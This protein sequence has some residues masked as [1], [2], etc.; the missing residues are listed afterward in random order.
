MFSETRWVSRH[1]KNCHIRMNIS[2]YADLLKVA[3]QQPEPQRL[4][5]VF[6]Q[7]ERPEGHTAEQARRFQA[8]KGCVLNA[9][10]STE[11]ALDELGDFSDLVEES[12][13]TGQ[14]RKIVFV[15]GLGGRGNVMPSSEDAQEHLKTMI[16]S[17]Q[18]GAISNYL[19][20][21]PDGNVVRF[22]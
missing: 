6:T 20:F 7:P 5:F 18:N 10:M 14:Y 19:A 8:G 2:N 22:S 11:K 16:H 9:P 1:L 4:L 15:S 3:R 21:D 17:I 13:K 12:R